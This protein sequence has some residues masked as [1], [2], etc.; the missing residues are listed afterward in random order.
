MVANKPVATQ[1]VALLQIIY[2]KNSNRIRIYEVGIISP[3][4]RNTI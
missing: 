3:I 4:F 1:C 2:H